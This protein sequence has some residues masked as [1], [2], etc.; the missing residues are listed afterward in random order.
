MGEP[1]DFDELC[2][3]QGGEFDAKFCPKG[4]DFDIIQPL[5]SV[6]IVDYTLIFRGQMIIDHVDDDPCDSFRYEEKIRPSLRCPE[7]EVL[8]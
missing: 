2:L 8:T 3:P 4:G 5:S 1:G 7:R 6:T